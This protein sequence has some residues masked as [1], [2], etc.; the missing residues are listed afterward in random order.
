MMFHF[1]SMISLELLALVSGVALLI[2]INQQT[3]RKKSW[4][5]FVAWFVILSSALSII[6]SVYYGFSFWRN[7]YF[8]TEKS[9]MMQ[10]MGPMEKKGNQA[11]P[12]M[13]K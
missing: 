7:G 9:M 4:Y 10:H 12:G 6:C 2:L 3:R 8:Q 5:K 1:H 11:M 13:N